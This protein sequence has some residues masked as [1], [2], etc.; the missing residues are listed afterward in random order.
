METLLAFI[1]NDGVLCLA[2]AGIT[3][4][5]VKMKEDEDKIMVLE[6]NK[7]LL[8]AG[9][10]GDRAQFCEYIAK[11]LKLY[12]LR[13]GYSLSTP[14][15]ANFVRSELAASIRSNPY[16]VNLILAGFD[17][18][19]GA[20]LFFLDYL[21]SLQKLDF[22]CHGYASYFLLG[23]L[24][25]HH[26]TT[27]SA[28]EGVDLMRKCVEELQTRFLVNGKYVLKHISKDGVMVIPFN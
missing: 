15:C 14:A 18:D 20:S 23:L 22:A 12:N 25:R 21:G 11:N 4:S 6:G 10:P 26:K 7:L 28:A 16:Q 24:D 19:T 17:N 2:D 8:S 5:I 9:E 1:V 27:L 13:H 3:R